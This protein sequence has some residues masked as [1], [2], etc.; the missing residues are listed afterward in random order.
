MMFI[1]M[2]LNALDGMLAREYNQKSRL[3]GMLNELCDIASDTALLLPLMMIPGA[4]AM[5]VGA[6]VGAAA[7][8]EAAG[9]AAQATGGARRYDGPLGKSDRA[10][11]QSALCI[12]VG[13]GLSTQSWITCVLWLLVGLACLTTVLR[14]RRA[15][16]D[17]VTGDLRG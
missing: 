15:L 8:S 12:A 11:V 3:G 17:P 1:R 7:L 13:L 6:L 2:A 10:V 4:S 16:N 5:A 14:V 9:L